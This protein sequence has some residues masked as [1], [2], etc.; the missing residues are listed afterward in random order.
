MLARVLAVSYPEDQVMY[1]AMRTEDILLQPPVPGSTDGICAECQAPIRISPKSMKA[2]I[3]HARDR[4]IITIC[5]QC[6]GLD[7]FEI[8]ERATILERAV[9]ESI[10]VIRRARH[11]P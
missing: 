2:S 3:S 6:V 7:R 11:N 8:L 10:D 5:R 9:E 4:K 1:V